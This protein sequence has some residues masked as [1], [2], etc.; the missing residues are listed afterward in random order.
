MA[1]IQDKAD[2]AQRERD[3]AMPNPQ[4][5]ARRGIIAGRYMGLSEH[6]AALMVMVAVRAAVT[7]VLMDGGQDV[8]WLEAIHAEASRAYDRSAP[9][10][11]EQ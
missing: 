7:S 6:Q 2:A 9:V 4:R 8:T 10:V 3:T 5:A 1:V 11:S